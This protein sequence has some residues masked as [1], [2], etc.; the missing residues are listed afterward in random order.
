MLGRKNKLRRGPITASTLKSRDRNNLQRGKLI[1]V[2]LERGA[3]LALLIWL[4]RLAGPAL[5]WLA[6]LLCL[7]WPGSSG[8]VALAWFGWPGCSGLVGLAPLC[9]LGGGRQSVGPA[10]DLGLQ[11]PGRVP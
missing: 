7:G 10:N 3:A 5:V 9:V 11:V 8:W 4:L 2:G 6:W 1:V